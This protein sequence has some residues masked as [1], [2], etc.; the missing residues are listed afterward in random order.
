M[1]RSIMTAILVLIDY[2]HIWKDEIRRA[3][4]I[5]DVYHY[6]GWP[7][8][9]GSASSFGYTHHIKPPDPASEDSNPNPNPTRIISSL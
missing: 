2:Y 1:M 3:T 4:A 8:S 6:T 5:H 7:W 9:F